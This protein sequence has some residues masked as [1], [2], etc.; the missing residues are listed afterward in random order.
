MPATVSVLASDVA[1]LLVAGFTHVELY[2]ST[3]EGNSFQEITAATA[4]PATLF[5]LPASTTYRM[6]GRLLRVEVNGTEHRIDFSTLVEYWTPAQVAARINEVVP[7]VAS[8]QEDSL[9]LSSLTT[10]RSSFLNISYCD[11]TDLGFEPGT[12]VYGKAARI[13]LVDG[14]LFYNFLDPV[15]APSDRYKWR[16][17]AN[18]ASPISVFSGVVRGDNPPFVS[19]T[20][21][22]VLTATFVSADGRAVHR[23]VVVTSDGQI[24]SLHGFSVGSDRPEVYESDDNGFIQVP[25]VRGA[26]VRVAIEGTYLVREFVVPDVATA[27]LLS[28]LSDTPDPFSVQ[29]TPAHL[30]RRSI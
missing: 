15:G 18:G 22:C 14:A 29:Q 27:D 10:G 28:V 1:R 3:D 16:F 17:S 30:N 21:L 25:L 20:S 2:Q 24:E 6:G 19:S 12:L 9:V 7:G 13:P 4:E 8:V 23:K 26:R 11:A 5:A